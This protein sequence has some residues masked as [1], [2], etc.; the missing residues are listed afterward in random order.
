[1]RI[2]INDIFSL[3]TID[4]DRFLSHCDICHRVSDCEEAQ[5]LTYSEVNSTR[6]QFQMMMISLDILHEAKGFGYKI[7]MCTSCNMQYHY[8][9]E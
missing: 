7:N 2:D 1:M 5:I 9:D 6:W 8:G 3:S 4:D